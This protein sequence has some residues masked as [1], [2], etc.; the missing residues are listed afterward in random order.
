MPKYGIHHIVIKNAVSQLYGLGTEPALQAAEN[1]LSEMPAANLGAIGPDLFFWGPDYAPVAV[2]NRLYTNIQS[3]VDL[4]N[5]VMQP[6]RD[7]LNAVGE[8]VEALVETLAPNTIDLIRTLITEIQETAALFKSAVGTGIFA[9]VLEGADLI[10]NAAGLGPLSHQIFQMFVPDV[11]HDAL[12]TSW[13]WFDMLHYRSTGPFALSLVNGAASRAQKAFAYGYLSH[14]ATDVVGHAY[15]NRIVGSP[16]RLNVQRH[17][18]TENYMDTWKYAQFYA[19]ESINQTLFSRLGLPNSL[20]T[21]IGD[22]LYDTFIQTYAS[23]AHPQR[24]SSDGFYTRD[25]IDETYQAFYRV[26]ELLASMQ[27][28]RP[29]KPFTGVGEILANA[30]DQ[31]STPPSP[32][33]TSSSTCSFLDILAAGITE[34]SR[35]CYEGFFEE[36]ANWLNYLGELIEWTIQSLLAL[37]DLVTTLVLSLP[38][39]VLLA[40]LY[41]I[42]L[43][44][45]Q[46]YRSARLVLA[47]NGFVTPEPDELD[48]SIGRNL[49]TLFNTC[50]V[51]FQSYPSVG[52]PYRSHLV[53]PV[54]QVENPGTAACFHLAVVDSNPDRFIRLEP[55]DP[56][57]LSA[58]ASARNPSQTR[59]FQRDLNEHRQRYRFLCLADCTRTGGD[60][61]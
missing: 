52:V 45:Y 24:L 21:E 34:S 17:V 2:L 19:G 31:F 8:P 27:V 40:L 4:Y 39:C 57:A 23:I 32:P 12:E 49:T 51:N 25:Q 16:Y 44:C 61:R 3:V 33:D 37:I 48:T 26:L 28:E 9:G 59:S 15:V 54:A 5:Q 13:Y 50:T 43:L 10:N 35:E 47:T 22:L 41:G 53:C 29:Q 1:L 46:V 14:I 11:Q 20:P 36:V 42:Q 18:I 38:I 55:F 6:V 56:R 7:V 30:L 60:P 58:Y